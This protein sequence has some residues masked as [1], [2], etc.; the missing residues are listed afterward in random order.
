MTEQSAETMG[1]RFDVVVLGGGAAGLS[2]ALVLARARRTVAVID[3]GAPRNAL[4]AAVHGFLSRDGIS[5]AELLETGR[6][7]VKRYGVAVLDGEAR[8]ACRADDG[9]K[10]GLADGRLLSA[11]RLLIATGLVDELPEVPGLRQRWGRDVLHCPYCHGWEVRDQAVGILATGPMA[12]HQALLFRQWT[13]DLVLFTHTGPALTAEQAEQLAARGIR[14]VAGE[15]A[16]LQ[17]VDDRLTGVRL[18]DGTVIA[19]Q[20]LAVEPRM[21]ARSEILAGLGLST[22][23]H[24]MGIGEHI[25]ADASGLSAVAGVWIAGNAADLGAQVITAAAGGLAAAAAINADLI[26]EETQQAVTT[27]RHGVERPDQFDQAFWDE[28]YRSQ[29]S[30]WSGEPNRYLVSEASELSPGTALDVGSGEGADAIWLAGR[31]WQVTAVDLS[32]VALERAAANAAA[33]G[34]Q[35][36][37]RIDWQ[38]LDATDWDPGRGRYDLVSAQY[39]HLPAGQREPLFERLAAAVSPGGSLL[40]VGHHPSDLHTTMRRPRRPDVFFTG[41]EIAA[42]LDPA[43]W[44]IVT[45]A[46]PQRS[47]TDPDGRAVTIGETVLRARRRA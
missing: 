19:R 32:S 37:G 38:H 14:V 34:E 33:A 12:V 11:R 6:R 3:A 16:A 8:S 25:Q 17:V 42:A 47:A 27:H 26:A 28:R 39:L 24:P 29:A 41:D 13:A 43:R 22:A 20:A 35:I 1:Q 21:V 7:E 30:L 23:E 40:I 9:F 2:A 46:V 10:V 5:P 44:Q 45:N 4:A 18:P 31:G 36:A 15:V